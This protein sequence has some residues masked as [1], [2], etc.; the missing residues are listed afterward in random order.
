MKW[1]INQEL[2]I[3]KTGSNIIVSAGAGSGK[4][5]VLSERVITKLTNGTHINELLILTFTNNAAAEMKNRIKKKIKSHPELQKE[6]DYIDNADITTFDAFTLSLVKKYHYYLNINPNIKITD[7]SIIIKKKKEFINEIF[8]ELYEENNEDFNN[9]ILT[10]NNKNDKQTKRIILELDNKLD[11]LT[12]KQDYLTNYV[13]NYY[14]INNINYLFK[15][16]ETIITNKITT[17]SALLYDLSIE[18]DE[19]FMDKINASLEHLLNAK[20]YEEIKISLEDIKLPRLTNATE[21][22]K[23]YKA[24]ISTIIKNL[25]TYTIY[26]K[27]SLIKNLLNT[28]KYATVII[29]IL[30]KLDKRIE[31]FKKQYNLFEFNDISKMTINLIKE[32]DDVRNSLKYQYK[33]ILV[34]EYQ[35]TSDI[36]EEFINLIANNNVYMVGDV[37]QSIYRFR[38]ANPNI[39]KIK[40]DY[41][42]N[43][44]NGI[45]IDLNENFR[46]RNEVLESINDIFNHIMDN[47]IG[48]ANYQKEHQLIFGNSSFINEGN[49]NENNYLE[50]Y[51][52]KYDNNHSKEEIEAFI[53]ANDIKEKIKNKYIVF[54][55]ILRPCKY[56]DFCI[57]IDR[58][59]SF[60][61]FKKIFDYLKIPLNIYKDENIL[62][63]EEV[64]L[65][66]NIISLILNIK[67]NKTTNNKLYFAS[68]ARSYLFDYDD[69]YIFNNINNIKETNIYQKCLK[70]S[71]EIENLNNTELLNIIINDF[72]F[73]NNFIKVGNTLHRLTIINNLKE[74]FKELNNAGFYIDEL[75]NYLNSLIEDGES[76]KIPGT[77]NNTDSVTITNI[78]KSKGLE[79]KICY[80]PLLYKE[81][82]TMDIKKRIL[83]SKEYGLIL[84]NYEDGFIP[85][86][87]SILNKDKYNIDEISERIRLFYVAL[88]RT[89]EKIIIIS[90][91]DEDVTNIFDEEELVDFSTRSGYKS[92]KDILNS[93]YKYIKKYIKNIDIPLIDIA[94]KN[95][96]SQ[97]IKNIPKSDKLLVNEIELNSAIINNKHYSKTVNN[98]IS[99]EDFSKEEYGTH[100]HY[101]LE[102][103]DFY[104]PKYELYNDKELIIIHNLLDNEILKNIKNA[105]IFKE[106]EFIYKENSIEINGVIDLLLEY[107]DHI[108]IIDYKL[109]N[110][111]DDAY[112]AQLNGYKNYIKT[113]SNKKVNTYLYSLLN[114]ELVTI[115][116]DI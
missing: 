79:Y 12:N 11:L 39:F 97:D 20:N 19:G 15:E 41:Y 110:T 81:F 101:I 93:V 77:L 109:K 87:V 47:T 53:I 55:G 33:E 51:N 37:K 27:E 38:N 17:I 40:Y 106:Y 63:S 103:L 84:P 100:M 49:N 91:L 5:A 46:S 98:V 44:I 50:I 80:F 56:E 104:N 82:N 72:D 86:F 62:I 69:E 83:Y 74:K 70:I 99:K 94:Y 30:I 114:S 1:T 66:N 58:T 6:L 45:K 59:T 73:Y 16:Y 28:Q 54:D 25:K 35:D 23:Y 76:I 78:H 90:S 18:V 105:K 111:L 115:E 112:K 7:S 89:K 4:T 96:L 22:A 92:Y 36:Q 10:F 34:D 67:N 60:E 61:L 108:D 2:A 48:N 43:N 29:D 32:Y 113:V 21:N 52:Y 107:S 75:N 68:I 71:K 65:I 8:N 31:T 102:N 3:N 116:K 24:E 14:D 9:F 64:L 95:Y 85:S 13:N 26:S 88:T 42:K 57:L